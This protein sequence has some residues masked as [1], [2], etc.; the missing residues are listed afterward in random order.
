MCDFGDG[1]C[2]TNLKECS[3]GGIDG[4]WKGEGSGDES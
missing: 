1:V 2:V 3:C 4:S